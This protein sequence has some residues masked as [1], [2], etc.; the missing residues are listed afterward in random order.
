MSCFTLLLG[1]ASIV[2]AWLRLRS[3]A[4]RTRSTRSGSRE[5]RPT[6]QLWLGIAFIV[7]SVRQLTIP[8]HTPALVEDALGM[9]EDALGMAAAPISVVPSVRAF[10]RR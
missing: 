3:S 9:V 7:G 1:L 4:R 10:S 8:S 6:A 2:P 5:W